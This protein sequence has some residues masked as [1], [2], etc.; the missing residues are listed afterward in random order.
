MSVR[1]TN[2]SGGQIVCDLKTKTLRLDNKKS[3]TI[4]ESEVT[5]YIETCIKKGLILRESIQEEEIP[6]ATRKS[7]SSKKSSENEKED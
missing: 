6:V 3:M 5:P 1:L 2:N 7:T 4:Q